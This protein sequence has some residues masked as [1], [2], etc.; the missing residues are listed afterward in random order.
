MIL[1]KTEEIIITN[2]ETKTKPK[3]LSISGGKISQLKK[4][5]AKNKIPPKVRIRSNTTA[6]DAVSLSTFLLSIVQ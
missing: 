3:T 1:T 2:I 4:R 5:S 6:K